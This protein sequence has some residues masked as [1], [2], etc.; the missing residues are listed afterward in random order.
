MNKNVNEELLEIYSEWETTVLK[1]YVNDCTNKG[2]YNA[3]GN[4]DRKKWNKKREDTQLSCPFYMGLTNDY[5]ENPLSKKR[6]MIVGQEARKYGIYTRDKD[7]RKYQS[8]YSQD[9][10]IRYLSKQIYPEQDYGDVE[11]N[12][13]RFWSL[14]R[15]LKDNYV[16]CWTDIDKVYYSLDGNKGTLTAKGEAY[17]NDRYGNNQKMS[18]LEREIKLAEPD[19]IV[20]VIGPTYYVSLEKSFGVAESLKKN[21]TS[22]LGLID[23]TKELGL[24]IPAFWTYHPAN[25]KKV[26]V[27]NCVA[28]A[29]SGYVKNDKE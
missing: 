19:Y 14:F 13:S 20:F 27:V 7:K 4:I 23:V 11:Y 25:R 29:L 16:L 21:L 24:G 2:V 26:N 6:V 8:E 5:I 22:E 10:A 17:L 15:S 1:Q 28:K 18:V 12:P 9:W 3:D